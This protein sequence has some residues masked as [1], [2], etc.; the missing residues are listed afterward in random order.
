[1]E[2]AD[3]LIEICKKLNSSVYINPSGGKDLYSKSYFKSKSIDLFFIEHKLITYKQF[4]NEFFSNLSIIDVL[5]FN[6]P[7]KI[8]E[9]LTK[10]NFI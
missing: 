2:K 10:C 9:Y 1:M 3:R 6:H 5:M 8:K 4:N 7:D